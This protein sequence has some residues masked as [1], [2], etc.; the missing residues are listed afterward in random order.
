MVK[1]FW[2]QLSSPPTTTMGWDLRKGT[3]PQA[4]YKPFCFEERKTRFLKSCLLCYLDT[5]LASQRWRQEGWPVLSHI[6]T[7]VILPVVSLSTVQSIW[8]LQNFQMFLCQATMS[9]W[10]TTVGEPKAAHA[11]TD[12]GGPWAQ[13]MEHLSQVSLM[14]C[15]ARGR[16]WLWHSAAS[17]HYEV[18]T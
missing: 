18:V 2:G 3:S 5:V 17:L 10:S 12:C 7:T 6:I 4:F 1:F 11:D 16:P 13:K 14:R 9:I 15:S 8:E